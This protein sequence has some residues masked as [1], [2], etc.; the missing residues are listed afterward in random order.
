[1]ANRFFDYMHSGVPQLCMAYPEYQKVNAE[2]EIA[3]LIEEPGI[4]SIAAALN[5]L[6]QDESYHHR[7]EQNALRAREK[8]CWQE[9][10]KT[11]LR[12]YR[13]LWN[14]PVTH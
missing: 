4:D 9:E 6:L 5:K 14:T 7:L 3:V 1:M 10:E 2:F 11:L 12:V 8:Y 13:D